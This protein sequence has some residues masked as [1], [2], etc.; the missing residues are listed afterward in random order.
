MSSGLASGKKLE[1]FDIMT[2]KLHFY[3]TLIT[4]A[5]NILLTEYRENYIPICSQL[6]RIRNDWSL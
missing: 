5:M 4:K 3:S 6:L 1:N 2:K